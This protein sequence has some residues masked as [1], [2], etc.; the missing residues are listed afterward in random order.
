[1]GLAFCFLFMA[2]YN[3]TVAKVSLG[4]EMSHAQFGDILAC[5]A[6]IY[7]IA[8]L[9][10]GPI[11]DRIGGRQGFLIALGG[12]CLSNLAMGIFLI[13]AIGTDEGCA[14]TFEV[15]MGLYGLNMYFQSFGTLSVIKVCAPWFHVRERGAFA[16]I[17]AT[18]IGFGLFLGFAGNFMLLEYMEANWAGAQHQWVLFF[19][20]AVG[21]GVMAGVELLF[22]RERPSDA[23][24]EDFDTGDLDEGGGGS[25]ATMDLI[26]RTLSNPVIL[27]IGVIELCTGAIQGSL[28]NWFPIYAAEAWSLPENHLLQRGEWSIPMLVP[29]GIV[30]CV[31]LVFLSRE[32][33]GRSRLILLALSGCFLLFPMLQGGWGGLLLVAGAMGGVVGGWFSDRLNGSRRAPV[34]GTYFGILL[35]GAIGLAAMT[36]NAPSRFVDWSS[37]GSGLR[38][39]D[40][41]LAVGDVNPVENWSDVARG[42]AC[43]PQNCSPFAPCKPTV[44]DSEQCRCSS[45]LD[46][47]ESLLGLSGKGYGPRI[48]STIGAQDLSSDG[49]QAHLQGVSSRDLPK[50]YFSVEKAIQINGIPVTV[51]RNG[52]EREL[53]LPVSKES[54]GQG[55]ALMAR[56]EPKNTIALG[57]LIFVMVLSVIGTHGLLTGAAS[58]DFGGTRGAATAVAYIDAM[59]CF[60]VALESL[61]LS[62][63]VGS[64]WLYWPL[65]M[66]PFALIGLT[67]CLRIWKAS[68]QRAA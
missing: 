6:V 52:I 34:A 5:G 1:M 45:E 13:R 35:L 38:P 25:L 20:P 15:L 22:L 31:V 47:V 44:W 54:A 17:L 55:G 50:L 28:L 63:L 30:I 37:S 65:S 19:A 61:V 57:I 10:N 11:V 21:L 40:E 23:G 3:I 53:Q 42:V 32:T 64:N 43:L 67:L 27:T 58:M 24:F 33:K 56:P 41:V 39:G 8:L 66:V 7:A 60:G 2:R 16:G 36:Q 9:C 29:M 4:N 62:R 14:G 59:V 68:P 51:K 46:P 18:M 26:K 48:A 49:I 12:A